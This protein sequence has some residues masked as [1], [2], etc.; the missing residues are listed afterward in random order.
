M[1]SELL[2]DKPYNWGIYLWREEQKLDAI[3]IG[4]MTMKGIF[5]NSILENRKER[6]SGERKKIDGDKRAISVHKQGKFK[7]N[8]FWLIMWNVKTKEIKP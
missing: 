2:Q 3:C 5:K 1:K 4:S 7:K 8:L 6:T